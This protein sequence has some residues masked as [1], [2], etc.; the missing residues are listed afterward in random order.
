IRSGC[1]GGRDQFNWDKVKE[2]GHRTNYI[3]NSIKA[4]V[5]RWQNNKDLSWWMKDKSQRQDIREEEKKAAKLSKT[6]Q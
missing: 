6:E 4:T 5:G 2:D 1:R 3:G